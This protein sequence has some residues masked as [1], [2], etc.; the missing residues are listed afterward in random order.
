MLCRRTSIQ[1]FEDLERDG[2]QGEQT[3]PPEVRAV[4]LQPNVVQRNIQLLTSWKLSAALSAF[5]SIDGFIAL[6]MTQAPE[7]APGDLI[8]TATTPHTFLGTMFVL[9]VCL[10]ALAY[11]VR[12]VNEAFFITYELKVQG[13]VG[14]L[15]VFFVLYLTFAGPEASYAP[16]AHA[17]TV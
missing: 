10:I 5:A 4:L 9:A 8:C 3:L 15:H 16:F 7:P 11:R 12:E 13:I 14:L 17:W 2:L 6:F 1:L